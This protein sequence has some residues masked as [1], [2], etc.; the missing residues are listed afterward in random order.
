MNTL[1]KDTIEEIEDSFPVVHLRIQKRNGKKCITTL[2]GLSKEIAT[3]LAKQIRKVLATNGTVLDTE[4]GFIVQV[5]GD[6][7]MDLQKYLID[8]KITLKEFIKI[9]GF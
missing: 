8:K 1:F 5:Q 6:K 9:H 4:E 2:E 7:R 3:D